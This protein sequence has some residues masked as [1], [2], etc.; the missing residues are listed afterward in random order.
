MPPAE[1]PNL[2]AFYD[3]LPELRRY[4]PEADYGVHW[5][6]PGGRARWRVSHVRHTGEIYAHCPETG[7]TAVLGT[8]PADPDAGPTDSWYRGLDA[9]LDGWASR[10]GRPGGL[11]WLA[12]RLKE[13]PASFPDNHLFGSW[14]GRGVET[15]LCGA[16]GG[17]QYLVR[18]LR[19]DSRRGVTC[20]E[21][22]GAEQAPPDLRR[23]GEWREEL[24]AICRDCGT[25]L[26]RGQTRGTLERRAGLPD[27]FLCRDCDR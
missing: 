12:E 8:F 14:D 26:G 9:H 22:L 5:T 24:G 11:A 18:D 20:R 2:D 17:V 3:A 7:W 1:Y 4:S 27:T 6:W 25:L 15:A 10:C 13:P 19:E 21:C 23:D 16:R